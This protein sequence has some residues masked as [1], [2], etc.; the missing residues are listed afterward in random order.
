ML[1]HQRCV[2]LTKVI[3]IIL[4][5]CHQCLIIF[6]CFLFVVTRHRMLSDNKLIYISMFFSHMQPISIIYIYI[7]IVYNI[8]IFIPGNYSHQES[9]LSHTVMNTIVL[10]NSSYY[11]S[12]VLYTNTHSRLHRMS[13]PLTYIHPLQYYDKSCI[14]LNMPHSFW[15]LHTKN[16]IVQSLLWSI[17]HVHRISFI[18]IQPLQSNIIGLSLGHWWMDTIPH[19]HTWLWW[20]CEQAN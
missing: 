19:T 3:K 12:F 9:R 20:A 15:G 18:E 16:Q 11:D 2:K 5:I 6:V 7:I 4:F 14:E 10:F 17:Q 13:Y 8:R 1:S